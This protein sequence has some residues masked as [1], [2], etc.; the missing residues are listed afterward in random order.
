MTVTS[1]R[2]TEQVDRWVAALDAVID[3]LHDDLVRRAIVHLTTLRES[4][5]AAGGP[6]D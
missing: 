5:L 3:E 6:A 2:T 4:M 1:G